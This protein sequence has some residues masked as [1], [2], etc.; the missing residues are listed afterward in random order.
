MSERWPIPLLVVLT[1]V[2]VTIGF[3]VMEGPERPGTAAAAPAPPPPAEPTATPAPYGDG[4]SLLEAR[5]LGPALLAS[6]TA[7]G[8]DRVVSLRVAGDS[9]IA[10]WSGNAENVRTYAAHGRP[11]SVSRGPGSSDDAALALSRVPVAAPA[12]IA[13]RVEDL[14]YV[15]LDV[16]RRGWN[17]YPEAGAGGAANV[18]H[19][20]L[21]GTRVRSVP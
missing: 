15:L 5:N 21:D 6:R 16:E 11:V 18:H 20:S 13:R 10:T 3:A 19:A 12:R 17:A 2:F 14:D 1:V 4:G 8:S 9:V 7:A